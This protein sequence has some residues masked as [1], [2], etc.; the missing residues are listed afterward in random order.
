MNL[1]T[2][3]DNGYTITQASDEISVSKNKI[4]KAILDGTLPS[5][6]VGKRGT[7]YVTREDLET[8]A[9]VTV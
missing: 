5:F 6:Q 8:F 4:R 7:Y 2:I 3:I 1:K 9:G